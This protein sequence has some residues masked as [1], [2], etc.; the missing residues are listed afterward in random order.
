[1]SDKSEALAEIATLAEKHSIAPEEITAYLADARSPEKDQTVL[2]KLLSYIGGALVFSGI[3]LLISFLWDDIG[4]VERVIL[5][6]GVGLAAFVLATL[7]ARDPRFEKAATPIFLVSALMQPTGLFVFLYEYLPPADDP[8]LAATLVFGVMALQQGLAFWALKRTSLLFF[9]LIFWISCMGMAMV[10]LDWDEEIIGII[11]GISMLCV[12]WAI[13]KASHRAI[14]PFWSFVGGATVLASWW[15]QFEGTAL[16]LTFVGLDGFLIYLSI[17]AGNRSLLFV[18]VLSL[19][20]YMS[21][22]AWE[23]FADVIGW[24]IALILLG[25]VMIGITGWAVK[26]GRNLPAAK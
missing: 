22:F 7:C 15:A 13:G 25:L 26:L 2:G 20:A 6:F 9:T 19:L 18:S 12:S 4:S 8:E 5:T 17:R 11:L 3:G 16:D 21:Y 10:W 14:M 24:P 1:M 23:Y